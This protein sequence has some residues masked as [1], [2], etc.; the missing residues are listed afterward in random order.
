MKLKLIPFTYHL[1]VLGGYSH[2]FLKAMNIAVCGVLK[3]VL[4]LPRDKPNGAFHA[5]I[6]DGGLGVSSLYT[7]ILIM[8][9]KRVNLSSDLCPLFDN[10]VNQAFIVNFVS[11]YNPPKINGQPILSSTAIGS[12]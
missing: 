11:K 5:P 7:Y 4:H 9:L 10:L 2:K 12:S 6:K 1:L 3:C 8:K